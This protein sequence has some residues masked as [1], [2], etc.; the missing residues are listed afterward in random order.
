MTIARYSLEEDFARASDAVDPLRSFRERFFLP[1]GRIYLD[2]NSLG[3]LSRD[4]EVWVLSALDAWKRHAVEGWTGGRH[5]WWRIGEQ[6]GAL[7][8]ELVGAQPEEVV[9]TGAIT[10]NLHALLTS[11]YRP[12][13]R[14]TRIVAT[15]LDFPSDVYALQ[16]QLRLHGLDPR[17]HLILV[18][19][20]DGWTIAEDDLVAAMAEDVAL[21]WLP[22]VLYRSGQLLDMERLTQEAHVRGIMIGFDLAHSAGNVPHRLHAWRVDFAVWCSY[23]YLNGGPGAIGAL[24]VHRDQFA[25]ALPMLQG[26][27]GVDKRRQ[28]EMVHEFFPAGNAGAW[29]ISTPAVLSASALYGSLETIAEAGLERIRGKSLD[30]TGYLMFL[31][32][33]WL[34]P[35][36]F[37]IGTPR[38]PERRGGHVALEHAEALAISTVMRAD[39]VVV[40][41]RAPAVIRLAPV[42]LYN[43]YQDVRR[44]ARMLREVVES[45]RHHGVEGRLDSVV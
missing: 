17:D 18:P 3:P 19:S 12:L 2:G 42:A 14:R 22:S 20:R 4:A 15:A 9:A 13:G 27:W 37:R 23:K 35:L 16:G 38:E 26:W 44:T 34:A 6:L 8:A 28:F 30:L 33:E 40:D 36:G 1:E 32:D 43:T 11:F 24:Y 29:Q 39:G 21:V 41:F 31:A 5:P 10:I 7:Q 45:G 25:S